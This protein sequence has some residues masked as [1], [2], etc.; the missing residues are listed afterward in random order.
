MKRP[1]IQDGWRIHQKSSLSRFFIEN[2]EQPAIARHLAQAGSM[3]ICAAVLAPARAP[4][5][6]AAASSTAHSFVHANPSA[7]FPLRYPTSSAAP[8]HAFA[9]FSA[10]SPACTFAPP[11]AATP[12]IAY[13]GTP[14]KKHSGLK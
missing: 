5:S 11:S 4:P 13:A 12:G 10:A 1:D 6:A 9:H 8:G 3:R 2:V 7:V 14:P